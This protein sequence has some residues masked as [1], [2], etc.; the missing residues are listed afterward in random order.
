VYACS[1]QRLARLPPALGRACSPTHAL[2][3]L[4]SCPSENF[5]T[6]RLVLQAWL[7][8]APELVVIALIL[9]RNITPAG[10]A[11]VV[12]GPLLMQVRC[13]GCCCCCGS[14]TGAA[15]QQVAA[16]RRGKQ[17]H[18]CSPCLHAGG[19][20]PWLLTL[21]AAT[22]LGLCIACTCTPTLLV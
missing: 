11:V 5:K 19:E 15:V 2:I 16:A 17:A 21:P 13:T 8:S 10:P 20:P 4:P 14:C 22:R 18:S 7:Q 9:Y 1:S 12:P 6:S 3:C